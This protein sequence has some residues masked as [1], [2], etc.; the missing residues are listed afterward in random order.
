VKKIIVRYWP[1][2]FIIALWFL[3]SSPYLLRGLVPFPS[4]YL[5]NN[6][7]PWSAYPG[8]AGPVKNAATPDVITQIF[9]WKNLVI[10][11]WKQ[12]SIPL[13][14]PYMFSGT[15]LLANYQS[16]AL[17]PL[18]ILYLI[19]PFIDAWSIQ[20]LLQP[21]LAGIFMYIFIRSVGVSKE[22][23]II[24]ALGFMFCGFITSWMVYGTLGYAIL[25]LPLA[26]FSIEKFYKTKKWYF[27]ALLSISIPLSF[28]SGHFQTS[29]YFL[30]LVFF[31]ATFE[32]ITQKN[33]K[34]YILSLTSIIF[35]LLISAL[36]ILP[37]IEFYR[38]SVRSSTY[39]ITE[40][41][42][43]SYVP[44]F[45]APD[46]FGNSVT[47]NDW[48]GHYAEWNAYIG[49]LP[50][51]FGFYSLRK[52][53]ARTIFF[54]ITGI[55][56]ILFAFQTPLLDLIFKLK[57]PVLSTSAASRIIVIFSFSAAVLAGFGVDN[58]L[59]DIK[60]KNYKWI[61]LLCLGFVGIF[62]MLWGVV[63]LKL[64]IPND[65]IFIALSNLKLPTIIFV[66][67]LTVIFISKFVKSKKALVV[68]PL[69]LILI[70][71]F[72]VYRFAT[73]W[74]P[75]ETRRLVYPEVPVAKFLKS[76]AGYDRVFA[77]FG[78]EAA[79]ML[80]APS[81]EGYDPLYNERYGEFI[82]TAN[83]GLLHL[84]P[85]SAITFSKTGEYTPEFINILGIKYFV[86]KKADD[87]Q[88]WSF[89]I[90]TYP[91]DR[92]TKIYEDAGYQVF[93]NQ[94]SF[95]RV[96]MLGDIRVVSDKKKILEAMLDEKIDLR[97]TAILE[98]NIG[99]KIE[100]NASAGAV[101]K[102]Y[103]PNRIEV[104]TDANDQQVLLLTDPYYP[105]WVARVDGTPARIYRADYTFRGV[106]VSAG[107][108]NVTFT[109]EPD[110]FKMGVGFGILGMLGIFGES[111]YLWKTKYQS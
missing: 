75:F 63:L 110:S 88:S 6:F 14:N 100:K 7:A 108:H 68:L 62:G 47:R 19:L 5:V 91:V 23:S 21:L 58:L 11:M 29:L 96:L 13:W 67:F 38:E 66:V 74:Q 3:F 49:I 54:F 25:F 22:G 24:S 87:R 65:K 15:P 17:T 43:W 104:E 73:K 42:P 27:L 31:Y 36:Q 32:Y 46:F 20:V 92:F 48:F 98:E 51:L 41:I 10:D 71:A 40:I 84:P 109:Y 8:F 106:V 44:T 97:Q 56:A 45:L 90:W 79:M 111:I 57:I 107:K 78:G 18:N 1:I 55:I 39:L 85:R 37:S 33:L 64:F 53:N 2:L 59:H 50:L 69:I 60:D 70:T 86:Q 9:P 34:S 101:I 81:V 61:V 89:P 12:G 82:L 95:P 77:N 72:D 80:H 30:V 93:L 99:L 102:K 4:D 16:A 105:G 94:K 52:I 28:F 35:G 83:D 26:L 103:E 76:T